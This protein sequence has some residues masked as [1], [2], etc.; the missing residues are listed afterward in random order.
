VLGYGP[1]YALLDTFATACLFL[2]ALAWAHGAV[3]RAPPRA[4]ELDPTASSSLKVDLKAIVLQIVGI[5]VLLGVVG[6][7]MEYL[8]NVHILPWSAP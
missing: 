7:F 5:A 3:R 2:A 4:V 1:R 8:R 6:V